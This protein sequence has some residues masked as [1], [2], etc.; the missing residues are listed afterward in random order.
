MIHTFSLF[1]YECN[2]KSLL[3]KYDS[4]RISVKMVKY[5]LKYCKFLS[6]SELRMLIKKK[7][8]LRST[9]FCYQVKPNELCIK[10]SSISDQFYSH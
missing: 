10:F 1:I 6:K 3:T 8:T 5:I 2:D 4:E 7:I 9:F